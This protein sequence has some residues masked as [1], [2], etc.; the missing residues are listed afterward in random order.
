MHVETSLENSLFGRN[1]A[2]AVDEH[3]HGVAYRYTRE[4]ADAAD[5]F[6]EKCQATEGIHD[7]HLT[8]GAIMARYDEVTDGYATAALS[9]DAFEDR[10]MTWEGPASSLLK[11]RI[12][13]LRDAAL[14]QLDAYERTTRERI[15]M[16]PFDAD[17][18]EHFEALAETAVG[19][20]QAEM[21]RMKADVEARPEAYNDVRLEE[22]DQALMTIAA[23]H[24]VQPYRD[25]MY[26]Q[27]VAEQETGGFEATRPGSEVVA[28]ELQE[29]RQLGATAVHTVV[30]LK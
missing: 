2:E 5:D 25:A 3:L 16:A 6:F 30:W 13:V 12:S 9:R 22:L 21:E 20:L 29:N 8:H 4:I 17:A 26:V 1:S 15:R 14:Q 18:A 7:Q 19:V 28:H 23:G 24:Q 27:A 11:V 10:I